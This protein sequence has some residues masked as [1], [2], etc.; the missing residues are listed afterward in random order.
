MLTFGLIGWYGFAFFASFST[1]GTNISLGLILTATAISIRPMWHD[2]RH[3]PAFWLIAVFFLYASVRTGFAL[4]EFPILTTT[5]NPRWDHFL[6]MSGVIALPLGWW[7]YRAQ[8]H[9]KPLLVTLIVGFLFGVIYNADWSA[10]ASVG[11]NKRWIWGQ[12]P[13]FLGLAS[14]ATLIL[15]TTHLLSSEQSINLKRSLILLPLITLTGFLTYASQSR[16]VW[17][18]TALALG[19][20]LVTAVWFS[21]QQRDAKRALLIRVL[22]LSIAV[23]TAF[24][25]LGGGDIAVKR[26]AQAWSTVELLLSNSY[27]TAAASINDPVSTRLKMWEVGF[28][29][30]KD[31]PIFGWGPGAG[32]ILLRADD[33]GLRFGHFH[34]LYI[35][36]LVAFGLTGVILLSSIAL[37]LFRATWKVYRQGSW[38]F[39]Q[40]VTLTAVTM[41]TAT[42]LFFAI[43]IGQTEGRAFLNTLGAFYALAMFA[44]ANSTN[45]T[46]PNTVAWHRHRVFDA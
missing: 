31:R 42:A 21:F 13:N 9:I 38:A 14:G 2:I 18:G 45:R 37:L 16:A 36:Y 40:V 22:V 25:L 1:S 39:T 27:D 5:K 12:N 10:I 19:I 4:N 8:T 35:E 26:T 23:L 30:I 41:L 29:A 34:N 46:T 3:Q 28:S 15:A 17:L 33:V 44:S 7:L 32:A 43:R 6:Q 24:L 11:F 20:V